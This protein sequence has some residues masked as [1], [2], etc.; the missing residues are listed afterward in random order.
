[1]S[2]TNPTTPT[3]PVVPPTGGILQWL[4]ANKVLIFGIISAGI[5]AV[6]QLASTYPN[7]YK[8]LGLA[9]FYAILGFLAK[10]LR[11]Q[12]ASIISSLIPSVLIVLNNS[13]HVP[14]IPT[15]WLEIGGAA[16]IAI[17]GVI[18]PPAKSLSYETSP[19]ISGA[20]AAAAS[21]DKAKSTSPP[22]S[23]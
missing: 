6:Q 5:L 11:G 16:V 23:K 13:E 9:A 15:N 17:L 12:F 1:M 21:T 19:A 8:V 20:K 10:D 2:T 7:D 14:P 3:H 18:A 4:S 22:V